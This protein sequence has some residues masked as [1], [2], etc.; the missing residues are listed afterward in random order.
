MTIGTSIPTSVAQTALMG[1]AALFDV[2]ATIAG[3][4]AMLDDETS[5]HRSLAQMP[6]LRA[7]G[8][9]VVADGCRLYS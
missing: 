1:E 6:L 4:G 8:D 7:F 3:L 2:F 5:I 9:I